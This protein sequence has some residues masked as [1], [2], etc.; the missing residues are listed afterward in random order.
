VQ[1][2]AFSQRP[3]CVLC[4]NTQI[5]KL[6][7][8]F[9][10]LIITSV[11]FPIFAQNP[12]TTVDDTTATP[13]FGIGHNYIQSLN[14]TVNPAN[15]S[16][17]VRIAAPTPVERGLNMPLYAYIY[18]TNG[19]FQ[20][21]PGFTTGTGDQPYKQLLHSVTVKG[22]GYSSSGGSTL[23]GAT[24]NTGA[25]G[26]LS[27]QRVSLTASVSTECVYTTDY[28]YTDNAGGRH[29]LGMLYMAPAYNS[30]TSCGYF[31]IS[32]P[33]RHTGGDGI[34]FGVI[35]TTGGT[36]DAYVYDTHGNQ[37]NPD[38][39][40]EDTNGNY[41]N[42]SGRDYAGSYASSNLGVFP[43]SLTVPGLGKAY[44]YS[45]P[46]AS[47]SSQT[48]PFALNPV[49]ASSN[50][51]ECPTFTNGTI[52]SSGNTVI[53]LPNSQTYTVTFD[54]TYGLIKEITYPTGATV[55]YTWMNNSQAESITIANTQS[56]ACAYTYDWPAVQSRIVS[57]DG[58]HP[59][60]EQDF[61]YQTV[62][63]QSGWTSK[64]TTV[65][66]KDLLTSGTPS[67]KTTYTYLPA[68][69]S[70]QPFSSD[71]VVNGG[72]V[73]VENTITYQD[74]SGS[75]LQTVTK[76]W[77][78]P[79]QLT[80]ECTTLMPN[81][82]TSG[83]FY[84]YAPITL[85]MTDKAEYDYGAVSSSCQRPSSS[86]PI[87]ETI[88]AY[89][90]FA[91]SPTVPATAT[92]MDRPSSV[93]V[94]GN[95]AP[96]SE[97]DYAYDQNAIAGV[98]PAAIAHDETNYGASSTS[99]RGN[100]T[101]ATQVCSPSCTNPV[102]HY[103]YDETGQIVSVTDPN[104]NP[105]TT[106]SYTDTYAGGD[107]SPSGNTNTYVTKITRPATNG[108][109]H[110]QSYSYGF[111][112]GK[113]RSSVDENSNTTHFCYFTSGCGGTTNDPW[114]R[115]TE[116]EYPDG[117]STIVT[118]SDAGPKPYTT[119]SIA[120]NS[121]T[122]KT[123]KTTMD[124]YGH[125][126][127]TQ[128]TSDPSGT[129]NT[130]TTYDGLGRVY[131][132]SN[133]YRTPSDPTYGLT[134]YGYDA[135]NRKTSIAYPDSSSETWNYSSNCVTE[136]DEV[137]NQSQRC[138]DGL[139]RLT[140][141]LEPNSTSQTPS[142]ETDYTYDAMNNLTRVNQHG[143]IRNFSYDSLSRLLTASNPESGTVCYG[144]S[145]GSSCLNGYDAN[146]NLITKTDARGI[147][148]T[149]TYDALNRLTGKTYSVG[150]TPGAYYQ[151]DQ[152]SAGFGA[153]G[154]GFA[155]TNGIGRLTS[156]WVGTLSSYTW[157]SFRSYDAMGRTLIYRFYWNGG[158]GAPMVRR[159]FDLAGN[160]LWWDNG[161]GRQFSTTYDAAGRAI[162][163]TTNPAG[164]AADATLVSNVTYGPVGESVT[165]LGNGSEA[166][167]T[168]DNRMRVSTYRLAVSPGSY[169][170]LDSWGASYDKHSNLLTG[171]DSNYEG[172][173]TYTY[174]SLNRLSTVVST[175]GQSCQYVYDAFGNRTSEAPY[176]SGTCFN[177]SYTFSGN[178]I[179][180][181]GY[182]YD[183]AGNLIS[184][185]TYAYG[186]DG[187]NRLISVQGTGT[188][189][190]YQYG[191][192][193]T[194]T[195]KTF[196]GV[197]TEL[198]YDENGRFLWTNY[199][200]GKG[201]PDD[202]YFNGRHFGYVVVNSDGSL[203]SVTYSSVNWLGTEL[204]R[205]GATQNVVGRFGSLPFGDNQTVLAGTDN[206]TLH[207]TGKERD[208][209]SGNDYFEARYYAS[210]MG[211]FMSP[212]WSAMPVGIPYADIQ[213]P[214]SLN[215]YGYVL[216]NP[217][218]NHDPDG[219]V[220]TCGQ[221][222]MG[223]NANGNVTVNANCHDEP[224]WWDLPG[225]AFTGFA[226]MA[227]GNPKQGLKQMAYAYSIGVPLAG[228]GVGL[229][230][231][232][233]L[234]TLGLGIATAETTV[235]G[236]YGA[237]SVAALQEAASSGGETITVVTN[238]D[239]APVAGRALSVATGDGAEA[240]A[241]QASGS[242]QFVAQIPKALVNLMEQTGLAT[243]SFTAMGDATAQEIRFM[244]QATQF[245]T[246]FFK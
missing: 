87:R 83:D 9:V 154:S 39:K 135:L 60:L 134:T 204:A 50:S 218:R 210:S 28:V 201:T 107:G 72:P 90:T 194:R 126:I 108:V 110:I 27:F 187:E 67:F 6:I 52:A 232:S 65:T 38:Y 46:T 206:D 166:R 7:R 133:P 98:S 20:L 196:N 141:V 104:S 122:S 203:N 129:D 51:S 74:T 14:E 77:A 160:V 113:M 55:S 24:Q 89:Q 230:A 183:A 136:T 150:T 180:T 29:S 130:D 48:L 234:T 57:Y 190:T 13:T 208:T 233:G 179:S 92:I 64:T 229:N 237:V 224:D 79:N 35:D 225:W 181:P 101:S 238:L 124:A 197:T 231:A 157:A 43:T 86:T 153:G 148:T 182:Q 140:K 106:Y 189:L 242:T 162:S 103:S 200:Y 211:R 164:E 245:I 97:T 173:G 100:L 85:L 34:I 178:R 30:S 76:V 71:G 88:T 3:Y 115:L 12:V 221:Q 91:N 168:Y 31:G 68:S 95:G 223:T 16:V 80:A 176:Q 62:W 56:D 8:L 117:G 78:T 167:F 215:L 1:L 174:D 99:P 37:L 10:I 96:L 193:G 49:G 143:L 59:A 128:L 47:S 17:S 158:P 33:G 241:N 236:L 175:L 26:T 45:Y 222:S 32:D 184:D 54:P 114:A 147:Q 18:D 112:D 138:N 132:V 123:T 195:T 131:T 170:Y 11:S 42:G 146:S 75:V 214:Q 137:G 105:P 239:S 144:I 94:S 226:N 145:S 159:G 192:E 165:E 188:N 69:N 202:V 119:T 73:P 58:V 127:Q 5:S 151:Y 198:G 63:G 186:Y 23:T 93:K 246:Q 155:V 84:Q 243:R 205:F 209:E 169:T 116:V 22:V 199:G 240:L 212:D 172:A 235:Q 81:G 227:Y 191:P 149:Y 156:E 66:T 161:S 216:N 41:L 219:H 125:T 228:V 171:G 44:S 217:L 109:A 102:T 111:D 19:Q 213:N 21:V 163:M 220:W 4:H 152:S 82:Q 207:F 120:M 142:V 61:S 40:V 139:G 177:S 70:Y 53:S 244:P 2:R 121:S 185:G 118:Y 15:G 25:P 36:G